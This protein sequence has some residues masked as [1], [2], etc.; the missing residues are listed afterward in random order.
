MIPARV[1]TPELLDLG[2]GTEED[3]AANLREMWRIN[4]YLGGLSA[5]TSHLYPRLRH[6]NMSLADLGTGS[7]HIPH[8]LAAWARQ[9]QLSLTILGID[10]SHRNLSTVQQ[11]GHVKFILADAIQLPFAKNQIDYFI[12]SLFLHHLSPPQLVH[13]LRSTFHLARRGIIMSDLVRGW[14]PMAAFKLVQPIFARNFLTRHDG[15]VS[16]R[17]AYTPTE[18]KTLA[19]AAGLTHVKVYRHFPWRMTLVAEKEPYV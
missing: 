7:G 8:L 13:L 12:S 11:K 6:Q 9:Q 10:M 4:R 2:L 16:I 5:L 14:L 3:V 18:L 1:D 19:H 17:R 15:I